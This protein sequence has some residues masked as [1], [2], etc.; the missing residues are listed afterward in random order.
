MAGLDLAAAAFSAFFGITGAITKML[1]A[2]DLNYATIQG[3]HVYLPLLCYSYYNGNDLLQVKKT[4][5]KNFQEN[6]QYTYRI[7]DIYE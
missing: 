3:N 1:D 7:I 4:I 2:R 5:T 6:G